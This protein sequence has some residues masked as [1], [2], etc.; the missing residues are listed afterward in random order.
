MDDEWK[1]RYSAVRCGFEARAVVSKIV[2]IVPSIDSV[3][4]DLLYRIA[5]SASSTKMVGQDRIFHCVAICPG[6]DCPSQK[7]R[8]DISFWWINVLTSSVV[9]PPVTPT[10]TTRFPS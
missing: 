2:L 8:Q 9:S 6:S 7:H 10:T 1:S 4:V 5:P 3:L